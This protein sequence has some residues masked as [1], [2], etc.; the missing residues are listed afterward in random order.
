[1]GIFGASLGMT[2]FVYLAF[3]L[4]FGSCWYNIPRII[5]TKRQIN[6]TLLRTIPL[7]VYAERVFRPEDI[8]MVPGINVLSAVGFLLFGV[9]WFVGMFI[10]LFLSK[11]VDWASVRKG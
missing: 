3:F 1:M 2:I 8:L 11:L 10:L 9:S 6:K 7:R 5:K 4:S